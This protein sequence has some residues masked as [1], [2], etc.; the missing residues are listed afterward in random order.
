M[1][2]QTEQFFQNMHDEMCLYASQEQSKPFPFT[3]AE[4]AA[5]Q[6]WINFTNNS[7][8]YFE[9]DDLPFDY[10]IPDY[11]RTIRQAGISEIA[12]TDHSS[13]LMRGLHVFHQCGYDIVSVCD[14]VR[15]EKRWNGEQETVQPGILLSAVKD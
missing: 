8:N 12:I 3:R 13:G 2:E 6:D 1:T 11:V 9:C 4:T 10:D 14:V 15:H 5:Y 7:S